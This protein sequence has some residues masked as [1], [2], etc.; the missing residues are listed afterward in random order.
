M[1]RL[2]WISRWV[3]LCL[4]CQAAIAIAEPPQTQTSAQPPQVRAA[5]RFLAHRG[6]AKQL[7]QRALAATHQAATASRS[8]LPMASTNSTWT[9]VGPLAVSSITSGLVTGRI[10]SIAVDPSDS[11]GNTIY[12][13]T[14]GGGVWKSQ[15][16]AASTASSVQFTPLTDGIAGLSGSSDAGASIGAATV[17]PGGTGIIL[18]GLGDPNDALDSYYGAGL[19]R[20]TDNGKTWSLITQTDDLETG[21]STQDYAFTGEGFAGFAWSTTNTQ[22]VVAAISQAFEG[23]ITNATMQGQSYEGL[24]Y[25]SDAGATWH[26]AQI[27]DL[28]GQDVQGPEDAFILPDGNAATSVVWNPIR[29]LFFAAVRYHGYYQ[30]SDGIHWTRFANQPGTNLTIAVCPTGASVLGCPIFRGSLT[31]NPQT[32]D[33]FSATTLSFPNTVEGQPS[34]PLT[35]TLTNSGGIPLTSISTSVTNNQGSSDFQAISSCGTQLAANSSCTISV[36]L[37]PS[38]TGTESGTL[39]IGDALKSQSVK[40]S[41]WG[42]SPPLISLSTTSFAYGSQEIG[43]AT[44]AKSLNIYD[45]GGSSL[46]QPSV[47]ISGSGAAAFS[48]AAN[49]CTASVAVSQYCTV[50]VVFTPVIAGSVTATLTVTSAS[51]NVAPATLA[52]SGTGLTPPILGVQPASIN[53]GIVDVGFSSN[54]YS[55]TVQNLGQIAMT[56]PT[57]ALTGFT[58]PS[59]ALPTD[60]ALSAPSDVTACT[61]NLS[62]GGLC[63]EQVIFSPSAIGTE[64]I[65]LVVSNPQANPSSATVTITGTGS[66]PISLQSNVSQLEFGQATVGSASLPLTLTISNVG[67]QAANGLTFALTGPYSLNASPTACGSTLGG[68]ASCNVAL[69]FSPT[70]SGDQPG[71]LTVAAA[72]QGVAPLVVALDGTGQAVGGFSVQP[73]QLTFGSVQTGTI[74]A[75]QTLTITNSGGATLAGIQLSMAGDFSL[76]ADG[77]SATLAA[78]ATCTTGVVFK[79]STT[80]N[81]TSTL[82]LTSTSAGTTPAVVPMSGTGIPAGSIFATPAVLGFGSVTVGGSAAAQTVSLQNTGAI[83]LSGLQFSVIG[84]YSLLSNTCGTVLAPSAACTLSVSFAPSQAGTRIGSITV[85]SAA[86]GFTPTVIGLTGTGLPAAQLAVTPSHLTFSTIPVGSSSSPQTIT[87]SNPGTAALQG[88][89]A[90]ATGPFTTGSGSCGS[91]LAAGA[92]CAITVTFSPKTAGVLTGVVTLSSS[93]V[94][95]PSV[96]I[97]ASGTGLAPA[98]LALTPSPVNFPSVELGVTSPSQTVT[99][100]NSGGQSLGGLAIS[101]TG[102]ESQDFV[103]G[104][105]TCTATLAAGAS[106]AVSITFTPTL[107][108]GRQAFLTAASTTSGV[109]SV[110]TTL[111]GAG[112]TPPVLNFAP[113]QLSFPTTQIGQSSAAQQLNLTNSGQSGISDLQLTLTTGFVLN[114]AQ[115]TCTAALSA[116]ASCI[117]AIQLSPASSGTTTGAISAASHLT[118]AS[119]TAALTGNGSVPP[120]IVT[121]PANT[122]QFGT[123]GVGSS[124]PQQTVTV[125]N[126]SAVS[127]VTGLSLTL[128]ANAQQ[129]GF[130]LGSNNCGSTIAPGVSCTVNINF[131]PATYGPLTGILTLQG[132][133]GVAPVQLQLAGIGYSFQFTVNGDNSATVVQ[134]Q[135]AN[136]TLSL[137]SYGSAANSGTNFSFECDNLPANAICV[138][139]PV[140]LPVQQSNVTGQVLLQIGTGAPSIAADRNPPRSG[141]TFPS[142]NLIVLACGICCI[143]FT[144]RWRKKISSLLVITLVFG[145]AIAIAGCAA[146]SGSGSSGQQKTGGGTPPGSYTVTISA[147]ANGVT[148]SL[149][150]TLA[151]N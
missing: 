45:R 59:G 79:P 86:T 32:G 76:T 72:N 54:A 65:T 113:T 87:V 11:S 116:G 26:L 129:N 57:F 104:A 83:T 137:T 97:Q 62:P 29:Q 75:S 108:G 99:V 3:A 66:P 4:A 69:V 9:P 140:Q 28:D 49:N 88:L 18:A 5:Q 100:T 130:G 80:G 142:H 52:L 134:G 67:R 91:T 81:E 127:A 114:A 106:C 103:L 14:T 90:T 136:Y 39:Y 145:A 120:S 146:S 74:S 25:S 37:T 47:S 85:N 147:N 143:P 24:Y 141:P 126:P 27:T 31:V 139:N 17:Q 138:F 118:G 41:G 8:L 148:K 10:S 58:G 135:S 98:S 42:L 117:A 149:T 93:S 77:C 110:T 89:T 105:N 20:S 50:Q 111:S 70:A 12:A 109:A 23:A 102:S 34:A 21:L 150:V 7:R 78:G 95:V 101:L 63:Y 13:G 125:T 64:S 144:L 92:S 128:D 123:T 61:A 36:T 56:A 55:I 151:V 48:I 71:T 2:E 53:V 33:T 94:G 133:N 121:S 60:F 43:V 82:T 124:S 131:S 119:A 46:A 19:L 112:L 35:V 40:L 122:I 6:G 1:R 107:A 22:L 16:A 84:D 132:T 30:S 96:A 38:V 15:N 51:P 115:T 73:S 68:Q 44:A